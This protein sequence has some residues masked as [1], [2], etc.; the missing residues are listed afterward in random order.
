MSG[1]R[2]GLIDAVFEAE[3]REF[4]GNL[5]FFEVNDCGSETSVRVRRTGRRMALQVRSYDTSQ[6]TNS[7]CQRGSSTAPMRHLSA[8]LWREC[9]DDS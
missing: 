8:P 7:A 4:S 5:E 3:N 2:E 1:S 6:Y 9:I